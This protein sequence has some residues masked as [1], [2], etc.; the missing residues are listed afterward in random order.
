M[1]TCRYYIHNTELTR[2]CLKLD[3]RMTNRNVLNS[4]EAWEANNLN[5]HCK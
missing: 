4:Y 3:Y 5:S 2:F 1:D